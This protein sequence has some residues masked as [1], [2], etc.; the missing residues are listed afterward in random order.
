MENFVPLTIYRVSRFPIRYF[1]LGI[2]FLA[3][4]SVIPGR[5]DKEMLFL[6]GSQLAKMKKSVPV[7][8]FIGM[9][10]LV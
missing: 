7:I 8:K 2:P 10:Q 5:S 4:Y 1:K 9:K 6:N 3:Q